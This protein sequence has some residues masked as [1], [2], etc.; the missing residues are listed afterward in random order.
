MSP[1]Q[2]LNI[3]RREYLARVRSR[4][5]IFSTF[6]V[7]ALL[8][9]VGFLPLLVNR[10]DIEELRLIVVSF[11]TRL[12][13]DLV[14]GLSGLDDL[15][16]TIVDVLTQDGEQLEAMR[17]P[18]TQR[19][20]EDE[21][22]GYLVLQSSSDFHPAVRY[23]ARDTGNPLLVRQLEA[24]VRGALLRQRLVGSGIDAREVSEILDWEM[25]AITV[26]ARGEEEG[27]FSRAW[28]STLLFTMLLY[29]T[30]MMGGSQMGTSIVEEKASRLIELILGAVTATEF[31]FGKIAGVLG[32]GLTQ[33]AIW[34]L[35]STLAMLY[36]LPALAIGTNLSVIDAA[37][38]L[39]PVMLFYF[40]IFF[41]L[42]YLFYCVIFAAVASVCTS[43]EEFTQ[44]AVPAMLPMILGFF[45]TFYAVSNAGSTITRIVSLTPP[46][47]PMAMLARINVLTPS[48]WEIWLSILMLAG[49]TTV[50]IWLAARIFRFG[51]LIQGKRP[52]LAEL[53]RL[54]MATSG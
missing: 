26:S 27:G 40:A 50:M 54:L 6:L 39:N 43:A 7:P 52:S 8:S 14:E 44:L 15:P 45:F 3:A 21:L 25:D 42:G 34:L 37:E 51:L 17:Q 29:M 19:I 18:L 46:F 41:T 38:L 22:D 36:F 23:Y 1:R 10:T 32:A 30:V 47:T 9:F 49:A 53:S 31:M 13:D 4:A 11:D 20:L 28:F 35:L 16:I 33:L 48:G 12:A 24:A 2:V 5:F